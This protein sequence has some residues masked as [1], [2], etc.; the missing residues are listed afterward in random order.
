MTDK[1]K[2]KYELRRYNNLANNISNMLPLLEKTNNAY[3]E[4]T[5]SLSNEY[6]LD[7]DTTNVYEKSVELKENI[8]DISQKLKNNIIPKIQSKI[9]SLNQKIINCEED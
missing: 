4:I 1:E 5:K 2:Y 7:S 9:Y 8:Y 3:E 6:I